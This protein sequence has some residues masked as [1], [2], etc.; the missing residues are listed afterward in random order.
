MHLLC[1][2]ILLYVQSFY[3]IWSSVQSSHLP[4]CLIDNGIGY[5]KHCCRDEPW[6]AMRE[7]AEYLKHC[8]CREHN[9]D[10]NAHI[11]L[12]HVHLQNF[13]PA[14]YRFRAGCKVHCVWVAIE[15][16]ADEDFIQ[17][18]ASEFWRGGPVASIGICHPHVSLK[19]RGDTLVSSVNTMPLN[20]PVMRNIKLTISWQGLRDASV[21]LVIVGSLYTV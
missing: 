12:Q 20:S 5:K 8:L 19:P 15:D 17:W 14:Q 13:V 4:V 2:S 6:I 21:H 16:Y 11:H 1:C 7:S 10:C 3:N 9:L 18:A